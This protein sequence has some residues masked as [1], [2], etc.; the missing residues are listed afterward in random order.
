VPAM[1]TEGVLSILDRLRATGGF[2]ASASAWHCRCPCPGHAHGDRSPSGRVWLEA[3]RVCVK[4]YAHP[5]MHKWQQWVEAVGLPKAAWFLEARDPKW[6]GEAQPEEI[7]GRYY[8]RDDAGKDLFQVVRTNWKR[9]WQQREYAVEDDREVTL[10]GLGRGW[11]VKLKPDPYDRRWRFYH[12]TQKPA[13]GHRLYATAAG[14]ALYRLPELLAAP[15]EEP[16]FVVEGEPKV[17]CLR[18]HGL[19]ATCNPGGAGKLDPELLVFLAERPVVVIPDMDAEGYRHA[20]TIA[21]ACMMVG[22][23]SVS[24][25][26]WLPHEVGPK[27]DIKDW[28]ASLGTRD[29]YHAVMER[30]VGPGVPGRPESA[31]KVYREVPRA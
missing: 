30:F 31:S 11:Y 18:P 15:F 29:V 25:A 8:Y 13:T 27:G 4:C 17:D 1:M 9:L 19:V 10:I 5:E 2:S 22:A 3:G 21:G 14:K 28:V 23:A 16:V 24:V 20:C 26:H 12:E 7:T 6:S